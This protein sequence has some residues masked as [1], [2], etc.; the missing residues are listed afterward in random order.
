MNITAFRYRFIGYV[1]PLSWIFLR[2]GISPNFIT[3]LS[4]IAGLAC[5]YSYA[6]RLFLLGSI[7]LFIS[8]ILD[9][10]DGTV[11]RRSGLET[12][13]GAVFDW[14]ADKY[15]DAVVIIGVGISGIPI[16]TRFLP[17]PEV[18]DFAVVATAVTG[19]LMNT[20][21]KPVTYAEIG[22]SER[23]NGKIEDP[24]EGVGFF[25]RPETLII[26]GLGGLVG[27]I[28]VSVLIIAICTNLSALQRIIYLYR[29]FS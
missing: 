3:I 26:L 12:R 18:W 4:L 19:S 23:K 10:L 22:F 24:L 7:F 16:V 6:S 14:I 29:R 9:L 28:W 8:A 21:I 20:F 13:F 17:L 11:A 15:T 25:G 27:Y 2:L 5:A 1:Q